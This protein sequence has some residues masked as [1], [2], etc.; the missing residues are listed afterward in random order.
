MVETFTYCPL[1]HIVVDIYRFEHDMVST[2]GYCTG[3]SPSCIS[4][5]KKVATALKK[6][7]LFF[8]APCFLY[9][10]PFCLSVQDCGSTWHLPTSLSTHLGPGQ[11]LHLSKFTDSSKALSAVPQ[12]LINWPFL[13]SCT[14]NFSSH[15]CQNACFQLR[16]TFQERLT[17]F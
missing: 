5:R 17:P 3:T 7:T 14:K 15:L 11:V 12:R 16:E 10:T 9:K 2:S 6:M 13:W 8:H 1:R 4:Q